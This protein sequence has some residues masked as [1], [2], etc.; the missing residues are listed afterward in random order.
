MSESKMMPFTGLWVNETKD[1]MKYMAGKVGPRLKLMV[2]S[3]KHK[4][5]DSDPDYVAY[6]APVEP[7]DKSQSDTKEDLP[8]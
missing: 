7:K 8:F 2:F 4:K 3:N 5:S 1:G 6:L